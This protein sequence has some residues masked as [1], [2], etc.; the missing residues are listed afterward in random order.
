MGCIINV[1]DMS[2]GRC[3]FGLWIF[4]KQFEINDGV[5]RCQFNQFFEYWCLWFW[6]DVFVYVVQYFL[7]VDGVVL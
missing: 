6:F 1:D 2:F 5:G 7:G 3:L 4:L